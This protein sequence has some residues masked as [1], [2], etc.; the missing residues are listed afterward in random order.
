MGEGR[1]EREPT[2][3]GKKPP[4]SGLS[5]ETFRFPSRWAPGRCGASA[6]DIRATALESNR[7]EL[8]QAR[9][10]ALP[11]RT[12]K[13]DELASIDHRMKLGTWGACHESAA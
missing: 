5:R 11:P 3:Q 6:S 4:C 13:K 12:F 10:R 1:G 2:T 7:T 8:T 9:G